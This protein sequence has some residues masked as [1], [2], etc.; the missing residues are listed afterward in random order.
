MS[1]AVFS[2]YCLMLVRSVET[3]QPLYSL[4]AA[5]RLTGVHADMIQHYCQSGLLGEAHSDLGKELV[6]DDNALFELRRI[7]DL[8]RVHGV[9]LRALPLVCSMVREI[10][11]LR[12][13]LRFLR[14]R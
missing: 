5:A 7:E 11:Q 6:F 12:T 9:N 14:A 1:D 2:E 8:R 10:E 13:E 3:N 4:G